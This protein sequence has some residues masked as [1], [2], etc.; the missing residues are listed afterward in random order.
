MERVDLD[1]V[2]NRLYRLKEG[3]YM[4]CNCNKRKQA[5]SKSMSGGAVFVRILVRDGTSPLA[6]DSCLEKHLATAAIN[7]IEVAE[8]S[9]RNAERVLCAG[10]LRCAAD[11][12]TAL[13]R[14]DLAERI[15]AAEATNAQS[16]LD[17]LPGG[18]DELE[19]AIGNLSSAEIHLRLC[20]RPEAADRI[21]EIR[22]TLLLSSSP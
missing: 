21:R 15:G 14:R 8:D 11:H 1:P 17:L 9:S 3:F 12:A 5:S 19:L 20:G 13:G 7:A 10:H 16:V 2:D 4:G 22:L 18:G 6:C